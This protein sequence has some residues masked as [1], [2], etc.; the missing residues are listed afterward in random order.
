MQL[1][2]DNQPAVRR[3]RLIDLYPVCDLTGVKKSTIYSWLKDPDS[4]FPKP[5]RLSPRMVRWSEAAVLQW[6][7]DRIKQSSGSAA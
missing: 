5:I 1:V 2:H 3:D 4:N 6:V 7:Q